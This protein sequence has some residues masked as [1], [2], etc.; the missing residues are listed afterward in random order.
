[1]F[2]KKNKIE[3]QAQAADINMGKRISD[4]SVPPVTSQSNDFQGLLCV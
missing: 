1:M 3:H 2:A 4:V